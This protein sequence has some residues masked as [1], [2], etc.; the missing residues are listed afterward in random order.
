MTRILTELLEDEFFDL[1]LPITKLCPMILCHAWGSVNNT[2]VK[3]ENQTLAFNSGDAEA[4][5][6]NHKLLHRHL[7]QC[8]EVV[9]DTLVA[10]KHERSIER[11]RRGTHGHRDDPQ[12]RATGEELEL[13]SS[14]VV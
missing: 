3:N 13:K 9:R 1:L 8:L 2:K 7:G 5:E 6:R 11:V 12:S 14:S 4:F 10:V